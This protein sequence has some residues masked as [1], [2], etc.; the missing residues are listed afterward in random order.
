M[1]FNQ[2]YF[3]S[4]RY[5]DVSFKKFSQYWW[6][7][8]YYASLVKKFAT[9][10]EDARLLE[11]GCGLGHMLDFLE[12]DYKVFGLDVNEWA[13]EQADERLP[14][15]EFI[16]RD[17]QDISIFPDDYFSVVVSKHMVE[18]LA[19]PQ[20]AIKEMCRVLEP[21]GLLLL[22]TPNL[23]SPMHKRKGKKWVGYQDSTHISMKRPIEWQDDLKNQQM[24]IIK[25]FSDGFWDPP[26]VKI[27]PLI[28]QKLW[29]GLPGGIQAIVGG[30]FVPLNK[31]ESMILI[32]EKERGIE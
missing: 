6:S 12:S 23:D 7:N 9:G 10:K 32:A 28:I 13:L 20:K 27:I 21:G 4:E 16:K 24:K 29:Y 1:E 3:K 8:R 31:G 14:D 30:S 15:G 17:A 22:S 18:H 25:V 2:D 5:K 19:E 11:V 26:Y